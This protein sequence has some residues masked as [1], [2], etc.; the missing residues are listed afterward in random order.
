MNL[1][2][3]VIVSATGQSMYGVGGQSAYAMHEFKGYTVSMEWDESDGEPVMLIWS[4][5]QMLGGGVFGICLSS[6][7]KYANADGSPTVE[8]AEECAAALPL[9]GRALL[10]MEVH[11]L[12][13]VVM[14]FLPDLIL[15]PP[16]PRHLRLAAKGK[17][18]IEVSQV[19]QYDQTIRESLI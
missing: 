11:T 2:Q 12:V 15:M 6:A 8:C 5:L 3:S 4:G 18:L 7:G 14:R 17:P 19:N 13:D 9:L 16:A 10:R 1:N